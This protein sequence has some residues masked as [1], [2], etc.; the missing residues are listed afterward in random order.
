MRGSNYTNLDIRSYMFI[1]CR[2]DI[3]VESGNNKLTII[4]DT[5]ERSPLRIFRVFVCSFLLICCCTL[6]DCDYPS[7]ITRH[8]YAESKF[9]GLI[10]TVTK[11]MPYETLYVCCSFDLPWVMLIFIVIAT[12]S[13]QVFFYTLSYTNYIHLSFISSWSCNLIN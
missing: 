2:K 1:G 4:L 3:T 11:T 9:V 12:V 8:H 13:I 5:L 10:C 7:E 6:F